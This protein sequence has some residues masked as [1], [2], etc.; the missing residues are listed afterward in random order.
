VPLK[1]KKTKTAKTSKKVKKEKEEVPTLLVQ[2]KV[3][4]YIK[5][6]EYRCGG[7]FLE[8]FNAKVYKELKIAIK[9]CGENGRATLRAADAF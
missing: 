6:N 3:R 1:T 8:A 4:D 5:S 2:S 9:R 7:E